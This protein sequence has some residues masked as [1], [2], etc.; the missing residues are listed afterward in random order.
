MTYVSSVEHVGGCQLLALN[1]PLRNKQANQ[2][3]LGGSLDALETRG[4]SFENFIHVTI[5][6]AFTSLDDDEF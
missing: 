5:R 1:S 3:F 6:P 4:K 2:Q